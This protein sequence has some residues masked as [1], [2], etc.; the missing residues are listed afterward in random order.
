MVIKMTEIWV[1]TIFAFIVLPVLRIPQEI[2]IQRLMVKSLNRFR[3]ATLVN[4]VRRF[5]HTS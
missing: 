5:F 1:R 3:R 2:Q 4:M